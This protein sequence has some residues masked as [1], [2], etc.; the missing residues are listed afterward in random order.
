M[1]NFYAETPLGPISGAQGA[2]G[3]QGAPGTGGG[4]LTATGSLASPQLISSPT[5]S[6]VLGGYQ[7]ELVFIQGDG[8]PVG[9]ANPPITSGT[10]VG[11]EV[12]IIGTSDTDTVEM[13]SNGNIVC[14]GVYIMKNHSFI[15]LIW[16]GSNWVE[17]SRNDI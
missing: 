1:T 7:R 12:Y 6:I 13:F 16:D 14:N 15:Y 5:G 11:Q 17:V 10:V 3:S 8:G 4:A 9:L 2:Q